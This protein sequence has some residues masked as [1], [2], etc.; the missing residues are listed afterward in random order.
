MAW[1]GTASRLQVCAG[2]VLCHRVRRCMGWLGVVWRGSV[3]HSRVMHGAVCFGRAPCLV[4]RHGVHGASPHAMLRRVMV[5]RDPGWGVACAGI[6]GPA[7][8]VH[9]HFASAHTVVHVTGRT[10]SHTPAAR[11]QF[12]TTI[13]VHHRDCTMH[14]IYDALTCIG[15]AG[16][17]GR[18]SLL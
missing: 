7:P 3:R 13:G 2:L 6:D 5:R 17:L 15:I 11:T 14:L 8:R 18:I 9:L 16:W 4:P 12:T 10:I 1:L